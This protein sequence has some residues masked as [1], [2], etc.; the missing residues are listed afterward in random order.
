MNQQNKLFGCKHECLYFPQCQCG[1]MLKTQEQEKQCSCPSGQ[2]QCFCFVD[3]GEVPS[4]SHLV[5]NSEGKI[6]GLSL[7]ELQE[8]EWWGELDCVTEELNLRE[9]GSYEEEIERGLKK[10]RNCM[11]ICRGCVKT[12]IH[13]GIDAAKGW[14]GIISDI[15]NREVTEEEIIHGPLGKV[16]FIKKVLGEMQDSEIIEINVEGDY[17]HFEAFADLVECAEMLTIQIKNA[18]E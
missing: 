18:H 2:S 6:V 8:K 5:F 3:W 1:D 12:A 9:V 11:P 4:N 17:N 7:T 16:I 10:C 13:E 15:L 14:V